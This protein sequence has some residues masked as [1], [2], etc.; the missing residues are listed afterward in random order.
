METNERKSWQS[1][2]LGQTISSLFLYWHR[3][4]GVMVKQQLDSSTAKGRLGFLL[5]NIFRRSRQSQSARSHSPR[6]VVSPGV[7]PTQVNN[8][9]ATA[10]TLP[11]SETVDTERKASEVVFFEDDR[12]PRLPE[13]KP[14]KP[15][16]NWNW[17]LICI[18][19][20][21]VISGMGSAALLWL[22]SL[23][24]PPDC[25]KPTELTLDMERLYCAQQA[26]QTG[27]LP[28]LVSGLEMLKQWSPDDPLYAET[29]DL[30]EEWSK[31]IL[32]IARSKVHES[33]L[34]GALE[35]ISHIPKTTEV[36]QQAQEFAAYWKEEW[37]DGEA[38]YTKAQDALKKQDWQLASE[39]VAALAELANPFWNTRRANELAQQ[40]GAE[41]R[42]WQVLVRARD[43]AKG[44]TPDQIS[45]GM[46]IAQEVPRGTYA[47]EAARSNLKQWSQ[48][49]ISQATNRWQAGDISGAASVLNIAPRRSDIPELQ[50]LVR[51]GNAYRLVNTAKLTQSPSA[52]W[53]PSP[54]QLWNFMEAAAALRQ[55]QAD[56]PF[57]EQ[58][59]AIS[60]NLEAQLKDLTQLQYA[61]LVASLGQHANF[62][63]AIGQAQQVG[64]DRPRRLQAQTLIAYWS[65]QIEQIEDQPYLDSAIA[66]SKSGQI[67][68]LKAAIAAASEI[69][70][71]RVLRNSAQTWIANWTNQIE[72]IEDQPILNQARAAADDGQLQEAI[73]IAQTILSGRALYDQAQDA[74]YDW[75]S[76]LI[77]NAQ[78]AEDRPILDRARALANSGDLSAAIRVASQI[79]SG[80][81]LS[82]EA[83]DAIANW[84]AQL[85]PPRWTTDDYEDD[86]DK[87]D[88]DDEKSVGTPN[89][90]GITSPPPPII[91]PPSPWGRP[92]PW[93]T[94]PPV[95][96][97]SIGSPGVSPIPAP[98]PTPPD[99]LPP[100][101]ETVPPVIEAPEPPTIEQSTPESLPSEAPIELSPSPVEE[102]ESS[103]RANSQPSFEGYYDQRYYGNP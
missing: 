23:P 55:V 72:R 30:A 25:N 78:I 14:P 61:N 60:S 92:S 2:Q 18:A 39:Q 16:H 44:N 82:G 101:I 71:G 49:L 31:Q 74:I 26:V 32:S 7:H 99:V 70:P 43:T 12:S 86:G 95:G 83:Q 3:C 79:G 91:N 87:K 15:N 45:Q 90:S 5:E 24:P 33:D 59:K 102:S 80:R 11:L 10:E 4:S 46:T 21:G 29:E 75:Q 100:V 96:S 50:D 35:A 8:D 38:L 34:K 9:V 42:A 84:E 94:P 63:Q 6:S 13:G 48:T 20:L 58:A 103:P 27:G 93:G 77:R 85:A 88:G 64:V 40:V 69:Q 22:V 51:F 52:S 73:N 67:S 17:S 66:R 81:A 65:D 53:F 28:E 36:Y 19:I 62:Q 41:K 68:D 57:Y 76:Q 89:G 97:P 54:Q 56:S 1:R 47:W 37:Q 98:A